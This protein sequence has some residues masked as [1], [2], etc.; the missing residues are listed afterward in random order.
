M[1][2]KKSL[3][4]DINDLR[5]F[6]NRVNLKNNDFSSIA[7]TPMFFTREGISLPLINLYKNKSIF[8]VCNGPSLVNGDIDLSLLKMPGVV[9]YG[10]NNGAKT[11][12]PNLWTSVDD[13]KRFLKSIWLDP[14]ICKIIPQSHSEKTIFD[15][16]NWQE[17]N[18][19]VGECPNVIYFHRNEKFNSNRFLIEDTINWGNSADFGGGRSVLLPVIRICYLLGFRNVF[20]LGADFTMSQNYTYHFDEQRAKGAVNCN[21]KTYDRLKNEYLPSLK[22]ILEKEGMKIYNC[23][24]NSEL[25]VFDYLPFID[26]ISIATKDLGDVDGERTWGLYS[27]PEERLK[28]KQ[29]PSDEQKTHLNYIRKN[30]FNASLVN[31]NDFVQNNFKKTEPIVNLSIPKEK[32]SVKNQLVKTYEN[33]KKSI[34]CKVNEISPLPRPF[35]S[36]VQ[37]KNINTVTIIDDGN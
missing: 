30:S 10:M 21:M 5:Q 28:W 29:Q 33:T 24:P 15:N 22:P 25:K 8:V 20:L 4:K 35:L 13:P 37:N 3:K 1:E 34:I 12:R 31:E 26:A 17:T 32:T 16:Q 23:N 11:V 2:I 27:K 9:T 19:V 14:N 36:K 7:S 6:N 18:I